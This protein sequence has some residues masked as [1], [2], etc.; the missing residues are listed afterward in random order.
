MAEEQNFKAG[1]KVRL[2][3]NTVGGRWVDGEVESV[4]DDGK[5]VGIRG[6]QTLLDG[7]GFQTDQ[8]GA[9]LFSVQRLPDDEKSCVRWREIAS[10]HVVERHE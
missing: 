1:D 4:S 7:E 3:A 8:R 6:A 10:G 2:R 5:H 9:I